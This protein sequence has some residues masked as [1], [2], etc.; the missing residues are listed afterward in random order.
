MTTL[1]QLSGK[2]VVMYH[3]KF[4]RSTGIFVQKSGSL[5]NYIVSGDSRQ[6]KGLSMSTSSEGNENLYAKLKS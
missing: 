5:I 4:P 6:R 2:T 1:L 3:R